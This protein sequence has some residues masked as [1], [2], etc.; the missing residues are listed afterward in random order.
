MNFSFFLD[1]AA[2]RHPEKLALVNQ[3]KRWTYGQYRERT[4][5]LASALLAL[6]VKKGDRVATVAWNCSEMLEVSLACARMGAIFTPLSFRAIKNELAYMLEDAQPKVLFA[7]DKCQDLVKETVSD[8]ALRENLYSTCD[9]ISTGLKRYS[10]LIATSPVLEQDL[11]VGG[12]DICQLIYTSGTSTGRSKGVMLSHDNVCWNAV[13]ISIAKK[14]LP[15][16][17]QFI[18]GPLFHGAALGIY[19]SRLCRGATAVLHERFEPRKVMEAVQK[20]KITVVSLAPVMFTMVM[21]ACKPGEFD[22]SSVY[23]LTSGG[24]K[25]RVDVQMKLREYFPNIEGIHDAYGLT[26]ACP[27]L[28]C[29]PREESIN[30][31]G[32]IGLPV[33]F[34]EL[35]LLD[36]FDKE[37]KQGEV[38]EIVARGPNIM[39]GYYKKPEETAE[40]LKDGWLYTGDCAYQDE[41]GY[42]FLADRKKDIIISGGENISS[43]EVEEVLF[44]HPKVQKAA[45]IAAPDEKWGERVVAVIIPE[46]AEVPTIEELREHCRKELASFKLP[47]EI[48]IVE[49]FPETSIGKVIKHELKK[50]YAARQKEKQQ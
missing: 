12:N 11:P 9:N 31:L 10:D 25:L 34:V 18:V 24:D 28:S 39:Q 45:C 22:T 8:P 35:R 21:E 40:V 6:G 3:D 43:R 1:L 50:V 7:D 49:Q 2:H 15:T 41:D 13:S 44:R 32:S 17:V 30:K 5:R 20:E 19:Q 14:E 4:L 36:A 46:G 26:E 29:L 37:V 38:G 27:Y 42:I 47:K 33:P 23:A 48:M 16:D